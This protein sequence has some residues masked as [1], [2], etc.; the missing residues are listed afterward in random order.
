MLNA[1]FLEF[2]IFDSHEFDWKNRFSTQIVFNIA[3]L[4]G[5]TF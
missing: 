3:P 5:G 1:F 4:F 2:Q